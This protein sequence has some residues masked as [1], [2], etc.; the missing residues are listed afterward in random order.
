MASPILRT[1]VFSCLPT[2][3]GLEAETDTTIN[4][5]GLTSEVDEY[6]YGNGAVGTLIRKTITAYTTLSNG[7]VDRPSSVTIKD[8]GGTVRAYT[9]YGYDSGT[10]TQTSGTP[11]HVSI[12]GSRGLLTDLWR[13]SD[14]PNRD[15]ELVPAYQRAH[16]HQFDWERRLIGRQS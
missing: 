11:Q 7:I 16:L 13:L 6:N 4:G 9:A 2:S 8:S 10:P 1:T 5:Y 15:R 14:V 12:T 3:S